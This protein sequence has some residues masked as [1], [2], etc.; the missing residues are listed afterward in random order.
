MLPGLPFLPTHL[1]RIV[2]RHPLLCLALAVGT[3]AGVTAQEPIPAVAA[4]PQVVPNSYIVRFQARSFDLEEFSAAIRLGKSAQEVAQIVANMEAAVRADQAPFVA[5]VEKLGGRVNEQWWIINAACV[6]NITSDKLDALKALPNIEVVE[7]NSYHEALNNTARNASNHNAVTAETRTNGLGQL[8]TGSG[9]SVAV[10]D[11]GVDGSFQGTGVPNRAYF[12]GGN[13]AN[14]TGG[15]IGGSRLKAVFGTSGTGT[16]D[17]NGHGSHVSGSVGSDDSAYRGLAK[18]T[19]I[20][21]IKIVGSGSGSGSASSA[22]LVSAWQTVAAQRVAHNI[23]VANNSF[24]GSPSLTDSIQMALDSTALSADVL[25]CCAAGNGGT[26]TTA[27]QNVWNGLACGAVNKN[28][29]TVASFSARGPLSSF[30]R[31]YPDIM[32]V[33][34]SVTSILLD[35]TAGTS[36]SGT[37]MASPMISGGGALL[38]QAVPTMSAIEA[39]ALLLNTTKGTQ[40]DPNNYGTG[41]MDCD[42]SVVQALAGDYFTVTMLPASRVERRNFSVP[43]TR[44]MRVSLAWMHPAGANF[45]NVDLRIY[46]GATLVAS[47]LS[48]LNS[49]ERVTFTATGGITYTAELTWAGTAVRSSLPVAVAGFTDT[50]PQLPTLTSLTPTQTTNNSH[51]TVTLNGTFES[52][53][54]IDLGALQL[55]TFTVVNPTQITFTL[56]TPAPIG[57]AIPVSVH[58]I[59]GSSNVLTIRIDGAHPANL[60]ANAFALRGTPLNISAIGDANWGVLLYVS[61]SNLPSVL[62][63]IVNL[64]IADN[65]TALFTIGFYPLNGDGYALVPFTFPTSIPTGNYYIQGIHLDPLNITLPLESTNVLSFLV[66]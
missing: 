1:V 17:E 43:T 37:S 32:G 12:P 52:I 63:G 36:L 2:M 10:I 19:W 33:G 64:G 23:K 18:G 66:F 56:P 31:S 24:S 53:D 54:R 3:V 55:G 45:D 65:F 6:E 51:A 21:G 30:G 28:T 47:S 44:T 42:A 8:I 26:N 50:P 16:E 14:T 9:L 34:V 41:V 58:N 48:T 46:N 13:T 57:T 60:A 35:S 61:F 25:C 27:S 38:R 20:V 7:P 49:W 4:Q 11:T 5:A 15:G 39:K 29:L 40:N 62:P 22:A 59:T